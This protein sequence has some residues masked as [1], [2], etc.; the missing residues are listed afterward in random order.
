MADSLFLGLD[1]GTS[2]VKAILVS[3]EGE[4]VAAAT[5]PLALST[6]QPGWAEQHPDDWW[7]AT[8]ES[9][10]AVLVQSPKV[11]VA[12]VGIS[13]QMHSSVFLDGR[14]HVVRPA[15]LWCD[16][17]TT[18]ECAEITRRARRPRVPSLS[19]TAPSGA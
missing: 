5:T 12:A 6:P 17:R 19:T 16:G 14:G 10:R 2:G 7:Q 18:A 15:L 13:G 11:D 8:L 3:T 9:I 1:V 4:V